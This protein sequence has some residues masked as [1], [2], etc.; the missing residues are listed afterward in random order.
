M[1][2]R[3]MLQTAVL[4][5]LLVTGGAA[6]PSGAFRRLDPPAGPGAMAP[7]LTRAGNDLLLTWLEPIDP[8]VRGKGHRLRFARLSGGRWSN[9]ATVVSGTGLFANWADFPGVIQ[10]GGGALTAHWLATTGE[11][12][13]SY[14]VFLTR[15]TDG[16]ATWSRAGM[17]HEESPGEHGFVSWL[18]AEGGGVRAFWL[19]GR[20]MTPEGGTMS[21]RTAV[22][23][24]K[25]GAGEVVDADVCS[26]CQTDAALAAGGPVVA[27]RD[28]T[29]EEIRDISVV[30]R[31]P[32]GWSQPVRVHADNWKIPGCPVN[33]PAIAASGRD[34]AVAWFTA[35]PPSPRVQIA[36]SKDGGA[37]FGPPFLVDG[38]KPLGRVDL[39]LDADGSALVSWL[40]L[41]GE[42]AQV[43]L[44]RIS[45][46][47]KAGDPITL[48]STSA[49][50]NSGFPRIVLSGRD[51]VVAWVEDKELSRVRAGVI[52]VKGVR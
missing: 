15:S 43:R 31:T 12:K 51:L 45:P 23:R 40:A 8:K 34:V 2:P 22:V 9:P 13:Y 52:P 36:F 18:P 32:R 26:C 29:E 41:A 37:T 28:H 49:S 42:E 17:L 44:R 33:G 14:S 46:G 27:Y 6:A 50:R 24:E 5:L 47:G 3:S 4:A 30:R 7:N 38:G 11:E 25:S 35:A 10:G 16:G 48:A 1:R 21:L 20:E 39:A 19:D